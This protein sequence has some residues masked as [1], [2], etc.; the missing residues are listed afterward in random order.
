VSALRFRAPAWAWLLVAAAVALFG[1]LGQWQ[2][3]KGLAKQRMAA[4]LADRAAE[5]EIISTA[6]GA[7]H[8][9]HVRRARASG[10]WLPERQLLLDGQSNQHRPGYRV[11][12]P[13]LL[14]D[15]TAVLVDRG[16]IPHHRAGFDAAVPAGAAT[17]TGAW[18]ALPQPALRLEGTV[19]CPAE[20]AFPAVVLYPTGDDAECLL[21]RPVLAGLLLLDADARDGFVR[22]WTDFGL[23]PARHY[24]Y[25][26]QWFALALAAVV[27]FIAVN[28]GRPA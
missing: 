7:P 19:N 25:A 11:W 3:G 18:R 23:P 12:T 1:A 28:R 13:L 22:E 10:T 21:S 16:W 17:V 14:A 24:G 5:P 4:A 6:L 26:A 20:K 2:L 27:M 8:G 15:G 9:L